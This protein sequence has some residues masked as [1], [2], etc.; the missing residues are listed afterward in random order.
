MP[1]LLTAVA[2]TRMTTAFRW[3]RDRY[4]IITAVSGA[5]LITMGLLLFTG[6]L[7]RLNIEAAARAGR[8]RAELLQERLTTSVCAIVVG[9]IRHVSRYVPATVGVNE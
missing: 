4:L 7:A 1:F 5:I 3:L 9:W 6:E 2:F 8:A